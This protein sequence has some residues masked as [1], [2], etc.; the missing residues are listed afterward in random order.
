MTCEVES[1]VESYYHYR[2]CDQRI[3]R[4]QGCLRKLATLEKCCNVAMHMMH[5]TIAKPQPIMLSIIPSRI[6]HNYYFIP[7]PSPII[8]VIFFKLLLRQQQ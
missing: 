8:S 3:P 6:S 5:T 4:L 1:K 7:M 2:L